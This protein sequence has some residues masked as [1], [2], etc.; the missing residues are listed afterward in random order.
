MFH[1]F[2]VDILIGKR[3]RKHK[4]VKFFSVFFLWYRNNSYPALITALAFRAC[5]IRVFQ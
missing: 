1:N 2:L 3:S 4:A 5:G